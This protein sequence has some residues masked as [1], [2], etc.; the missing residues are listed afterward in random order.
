ML[1]QTA[2]RLS[3]CR[4]KQVKM[5]V[6]TENILLKILHCILSDVKTKVRPLGSITDYLILSVKIL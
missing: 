2:Q 3:L 6:K 1:I 5:Y 4:L